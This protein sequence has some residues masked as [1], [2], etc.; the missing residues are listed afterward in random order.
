MM[1]P[2]HHF[3]PASSLSM[4]ALADLYTRAFDD[5]FYPAAT[6]AEELASRIPAEQLLLDHSPLLYVDDTP[7]GLAL[8]ALRGARSCCGG[9]GIVPAQRGRGLA[10]P[11]TLALLD[12]ARQCGA[13]AMTLIVLAQN[14]RAI[15][16]YCHA[17][18]TIWREIWCFEWPP[19][20]AALATSA[21]GE[22]VGA[23]VPDLLAL[24]PEWPP[25]APIWSREAATLRALDGLTGLALTKRGSLAG[26]LVLRRAPD[27]AADILAIGARSAADATLALAALQRQGGR[28]TCFNEPADS[29]GAAAMDTLGFARTFRRYEMCIS[30]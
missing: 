14:E 28:I 26:Y 23:A 18:F 4:E 24:G 21:S 30:L 17:G 20:G 29:P 22:L 16:S 27:G 10:L 8:L 1:I 6:T 19:G 13:R 5:Y 25:V 2:A 7:V 12:Q 3:V 15:K 11:L 9:F